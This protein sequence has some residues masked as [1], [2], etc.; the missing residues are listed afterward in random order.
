MTVGQST[1]A[2]LRPLEEFALLHARTM[3]S[4]GAK[5]IDLSYPNPRSCRDI[6]AHHL[7]GDL[8]SQATISDL[9]YTPFGGLTQAR[10]NIAGALA[11]RFGLPFRF[12]DIILTPGAAAALRVAFQVLFQPGDQVIL[13]SPCWMDYPVYFRSLGICVA[14]VPSG[15]DKHLDCDAIEAAWTPATR[16]VVVSQPACPT[17]VVYPEHEI[18]AL[19][20]LLDAMAARHGQQPV[21]ISDE[22]HRDTVW[23]GAAFTTPLSIYPQSLSVYSFGKAWSMQGQ[24]IGY[25]ALS[26]AISRRQELTT[27]LVRMMRV[28]GHCAPTALMQRVASRLAGLSPDTA[29]LADL[30]E[31]ARNDLTAAGYDVIPADATSFVYVRAP[32]GDEASFATRAAR[33]GVLVMPSG[34]FHEHGYFRAALN[35]GHPEIGPAVARLAAACNGA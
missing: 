8:A 5:A 17:G 23:S 1:D 15:P 12:T 24:R 10:R 13:I 35:V 30:Q 18:R 11:R 32:D 6:R 34:I 2:L 25:V 4:F 19:A 33:H 29:D 22:A 9:Q 27:A 28:T 7:L 20:S 26:P 3:R 21:L 16:G 31:H 14:I